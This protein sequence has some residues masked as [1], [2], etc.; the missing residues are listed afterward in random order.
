[1]V[2]LQVAG[3]VHSEYGKVN[4]LR[5]SNRAVSPA[6]ESV[7]ALKCSGGFSVGR[8]TSGNPSPSKSPT[9]IDPSRFVPKLLM[10]GN[11]PM[12]SRKLMGVPKFPEPLGPPFR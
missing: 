1:M 9:A 3:A 2:L 7:A 10:L 11:S 5:V 8:M 4:P 6:P 12:L